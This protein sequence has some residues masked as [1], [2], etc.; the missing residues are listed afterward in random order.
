[1]NPDF[2]LLDPDGDPDRHQNWTRW[3]LGTRHSTLPLQEIMTKSIHNFFSYPTTDKQTNRTDRQTNRQT[4]KQ[5]E[6]KQP[7]SADVIKCSNFII[8]IYC[9]FSRR[10]YTV[11]GVQSSTPGWIRSRTFRRRPLRRRTLRRWRC[12][13]RQQAW[14]TWQHVT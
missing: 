7:H 5:T 4:D 13:R 10:R 8:F 9:I 14:P 2:G 1:V 12:T 6:V 3:S 11:R